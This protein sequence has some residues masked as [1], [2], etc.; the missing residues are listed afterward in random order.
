MEN[1]ATRFADFLEG[2][3]ERARALTVD[4]LAK[5]ITLGAVGIGAAV[6]ALVALV[7][8]GVGLVRLLA[9]GVG[10]TPAYAI[11]GGLFLIAGWFFWR[12]RNQISE[13]SN[14]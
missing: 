6:L 11:L 8:L 10:E 9:L 7:F 12:K 5:V 4:R 2:I 13:D 14:G 1:F 3:A